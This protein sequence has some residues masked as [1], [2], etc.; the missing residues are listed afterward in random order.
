[1]SDATQP[2]A[3]LGPREASAKRP[4]KTRKALLAAGFVS[5][6]LYVVATD[7]VAAALWDNYSRTGEMVVPAV[8]RRIARTTCA[9]RACWR[10][11]HAADDR[12]RVRHLAIGNRNRALR[13]TGR[14]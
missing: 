11:L 12:L 8:C 5:S 9:H 13:V 6:L 14:S 10:R 3:A 4:T 7:V 2:V 1:M